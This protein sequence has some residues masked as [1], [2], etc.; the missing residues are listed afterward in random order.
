MRNER[1]F[2]ITNMTCCPFYETCSDRD[3]EKCKWN[4]SICDGM[5]YMMALSELPRKFMHKQNL[6]ILQLGS[7]DTYTYI[8]TALNDMT[9]FVNNGCQ[10]YFYGS[11]GTGKT[12][13]A[14]KMLT[15]YF[16]EMALHGHA[17]HYVRGL[18]INVPKLLIDVKHYMG[19]YVEDHEQLL[20]EI[21]VAPIVIWDDIFQ[22]DPTTYE[23]QLL[24]SFIDQRLNNGL[25]NIFTSNLSPDDL[26][27][28]D[29]RLHSRVCTTADCLKFAGQDKRFNH[30]K[31]SDIANIDL[32]N[33]KNINNIN[34]YYSPED[35][36]TEP[37]PDNNIMF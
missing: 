17:G 25:A 24:Y 18:Y 19:R 8:E 16:A 3:T 5:N 27:V 4:C 23:S 36:I 14:V 20:N 33:P 21:C 6:D 32:H 34:D 1:Y 7:G 10:A 31:F 9:T 11:V 30:T 15:T 22:S 29:S 13:W 2:T 28:Y 37:K 35:S 26:Y 12:C